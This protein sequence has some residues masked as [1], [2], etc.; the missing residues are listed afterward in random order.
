LEW[1]PNSVTVAVSGAV[2]GD[3]VVL[4][5]NFD[6]GWRV[7]GAAALNHEDTV[8]APISQASQVFVFRYR[9]R[10]LAWS[11]FVFAITVGGII[12]AFRLRRRWL[13]PVAVEHAAGANASVTFVESPPC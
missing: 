5:Q 11:L 8:A 7:N 4:N 9:P 3:V 2:P 10:P 13:K 6:P 12:A 1:T